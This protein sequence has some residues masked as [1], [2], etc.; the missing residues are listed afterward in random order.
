MWSALVR[1]TPQIEKVAETMLGL[2]HDAAVRCPDGVGKD[3]T[4]P[5]LSFCQVA[6]EVHD[7]GLTNLTGED[8]LAIAHTSGDPA[9]FRVRLVGLIEIGLKTAD[10]PQSHPRGDR[11]R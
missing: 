8:C 6:A 10:S 7:V 4:P 9:G 2:C 3:R 5:T 1:E 11:I